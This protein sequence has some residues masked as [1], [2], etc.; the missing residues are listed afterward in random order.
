M[1]LAK[2]ISALHLTFWVLCRHQIVQPITGKWHLTNSLI[3][4]A[5]ESIPFQGNLLKLSSLSFFCFRILFTIAFV[6]LCSVWCCFCMDINFT[7]HVHPHSCLPTQNP[8][9]LACRLRSCG[10]FNCFRVSVYYCFHAQWSE[11]R[12][13]WK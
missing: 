8:K 11:L 10:T 5:S 6:V 2:L 13:I 9:F 4:M 1:F 12:I 7:V 3:R